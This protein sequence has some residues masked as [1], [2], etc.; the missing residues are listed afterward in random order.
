L[1]VHRAKD[2]SKGKGRLHKLRTNNSR[3]R[4]RMIHPKASFLA[5][6][7]IIDLVDKGV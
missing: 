4:D 2:N 7:M 3:T 6:V 1:D 5:Q